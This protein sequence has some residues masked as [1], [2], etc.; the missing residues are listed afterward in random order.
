MQRELRQ[1]NW[2]SLLLEVCVWSMEVTRTA[3]LWLEWSVAWRWLGDGLTAESGSATDHRRWCLPLLPLF[4]CM[5]L[6]GGGAQWLCL[7]MTMY[8]QHKVRLSM[9]ELSKVH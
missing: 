5:L 1:R 6:A 9:L 2:Q 4:W 7:L 3:L 8:R